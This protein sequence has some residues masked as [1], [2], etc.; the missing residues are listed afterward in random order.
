MSWCAI[1]VARAAPERINHP[2]LHDDT[3]AI[4]HNN[5]SNL[6]ATF[7]H[8]SFRSARLGALD[9]VRKVMDVQVTILLEVSILLLHPCYCGVFSSDGFFPSCFL[10]WWRRRCVDENGDPKAYKVIYG[11]RIWQFSR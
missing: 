9:S 10:L 11:W 3:V 1:R 2:Q 7:A 6:V 5:I 4:H 8:W